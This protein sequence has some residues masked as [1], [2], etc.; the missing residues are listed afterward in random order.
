MGSLYRQIDQ[1]TLP[2]KIRKRGYHHT[3]YVSFS[4]TAPPYTPNSNPILRLSFLTGNGSVLSPYANDPFPSVSKWRE[5]HFH[6]RI[7]LPTEGPYFCQTGPKHAR[8]EKCFD[9]S[10]V[11]SFSPGLI[12]SSTSNARI[13]DSAPLHGRKSNPSPG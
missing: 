11:K 2:T 13:K 8:K 3:G 5:G 4:P 9:C 6:C 10:S 12:T 1:S 7:D